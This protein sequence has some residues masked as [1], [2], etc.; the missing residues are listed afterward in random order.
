MIKL[1]G[2]RGDSPILEDSCPWLLYT[3]IHLATANFMIWC[4]FVVRY[5]MFVLPTWLFLFPFFVYIH[6]FNS[7]QVEMLF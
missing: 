2:Y 3:Y 7:S 1:V 5:V 4:I 6:S